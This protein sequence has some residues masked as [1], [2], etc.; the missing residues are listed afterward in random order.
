MV[1]AHMIGTSAMFESTQHYAVAEDP[2]VRF[3]AEYT[4]GRGGISGSYRL[5][6]RLMRYSTAPWFP[7]AA[8]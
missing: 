5:R 4:M 8:Y 2:F 1:N 6:L 7:D 3:R